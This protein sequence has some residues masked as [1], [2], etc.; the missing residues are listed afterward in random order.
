MARCLGSFHGVCFF[1]AGTNQG[2][3][4]CYQYYSRASSNAFVLRGR[5]AIWVWYDC[6][7]ENT[8]REVPNMIS[9]VAVDM[10]ATATRVQMYILSLSL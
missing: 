10:A 2:S 9:W 8:E 3:G 5:R 1:M 6:S 7:R 4:Y